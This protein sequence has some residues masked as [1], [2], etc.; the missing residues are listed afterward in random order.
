MPARRI[1]EKGR[2]WNLLGDV[3]RPLVRAEEVVRRADSQR[4][5]GDALEFIASEARRYRRVVQQTKPPAAHRQDVRHHLGHPRLLRGARL[6]YDLRRCRQDG[7]QYQVMGEPD[8][9]PEEEIR[10]QRRFE[11]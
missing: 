9:A 2:A 7:T 10:S 8:D 6:S 5:C 4:G 11:E 1:A 3:A